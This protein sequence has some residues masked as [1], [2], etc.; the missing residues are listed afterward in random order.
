MS[1]LGLNEKINL[2]GLSTVNNKLPDDWDH[3]ASKFI[4]YGYGISISPI[5]LVSAYSTLVNG[6]VKVK[7]TIILNSDRVQ[8][9]ILSESTSFKVN[10]LLKKVDKLVVGGAMANT[11]LAAKGYKTGKSLI[12]KDFFTISFT[13]NNISNKPS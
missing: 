11:F 10:N 12:E 7:P 8:K 9:K 1:K 2:Q 6:G 13:K 3:L 4:S 5:S